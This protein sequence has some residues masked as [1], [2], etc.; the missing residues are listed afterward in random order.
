MPPLLILCL[1][2][3]WSAS[4][5]Q[6]VAAST[7][8]E[9]QLIQAKK[10]A[11]ELDANLDSAYNALLRTE[12]RLQTVFDGIPAQV[13]AG[14][15]AGYRRGFADGVGLVGGIAGGASIGALSGPVGAV[16]G[17]ASGAAV[18]G[19]VMLYRKL[20]KRHKTKPVTASP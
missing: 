12:I 2:L 19:G 18:V 5:A 17:A 13:R 4:I 6:S 16:V 15:V 14:E 3:T 8:C 7:P 11:V 1:M 20:F 9:T 10:D